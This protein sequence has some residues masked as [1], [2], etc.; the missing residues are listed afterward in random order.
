MKM[1]SRIVLTMAL[2]AGIP[3]TQVHGQM[4]TGTLTGRVV[5]EAT[6]APLAGAAVTVRSPS[7]QGTRTALTSDNGD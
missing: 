2:L 3:A 5:E 6:S 4:P 7:L 1:K